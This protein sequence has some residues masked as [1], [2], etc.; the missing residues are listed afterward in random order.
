MV[1]RHSEVFFIVFQNAYESHWIQGIK[2]FISVLLFGWWNR[3]LWYLPFIFVGNDT[4]TPCSIFYI[5]I[6]HEF[7][8]A[9]NCIENYQY[10]V[11]QTTIERC[12]AWSRSEKRVCVNDNVRLEMYLWNWDANKYNGKSGRK[13]AL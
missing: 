7:Q 13:G 6:N 9:C 3:K 2:W 11:K 4:Y 12:T 10:I 8:L 5:V 1:V